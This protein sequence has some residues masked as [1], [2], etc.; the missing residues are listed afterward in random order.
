MRALKLA[1]IFAVVVLINFNDA[2]PASEAQTRT[3]R[4][5]VAEPSEPEEGSLGAEPEEGGSP[6]S[7]PLPDDDTPA[8]GLGGATATASVVVEADDVRYPINKGNFGGKIMKEIEVYSLYKNLEH[9]KKLTPGFWTWAQTAPG[10]NYRWDTHRPCP[11][12]YEN[13]YPVFG[14]S[15]DGAIPEADKPNVV[16]LEYWQATDMRHCAYVRKYPNAERATVSIIFRD[17]EGNVIVRD[18]VKYVRFD[19]K[20]DADIPFK[21]PEDDMW[22]LMTLDS[23]NWNP[24]Y[25]V[26]IREDMRIKVVAYDT[27]GHNHYAATTLDVSS[28]FTRGEWHTVEVYYEDGSENGTVAYYLD[29]VRQDI[30]TG[31]DTS[32][33]V[34][35]G[36]REIIL[37]CCKGKS[38]EGKVYIDAVRAHNTYIGVDPGDPR[39]FIR[40]V[41][42]DSSASTIDDFLYF[43]EKAGA[44]PVVQTVLYPPGDN[45]E[46]F[47][48]QFSA[49]LVEYIN[50]E[51]DPDFINKAK[52]LD[53]THNTPSDNWANLRAARGRV[54]PYNVQYFTMGNEPYWAE[55]WPKEQPSLYADACYEHA[56]K[57]KEVDPSI[58]IGVFMY[59]GSGWDRAVLTK[60]EYILDWV[61][62]QHDYSYEPGVN[63]SD[64]VPRLL[65]ISAARF[66]GTGKPFLRRHTEGR[67]RLRQY[68]THRDD[69]DEMITSQDEHGFSL[70]YPPGAG[71]DLGYAIYRLGY[72]LETIEQGG[73]NA[74]DC[75]WLLINDRKYVYGVIGSDCLNPSYWAYRLFYEHFGA[76]YLKVNTSS[77]EYTIFSYRTGA[78]LYETPYISAYA[79]LSEDDST[80][81]I[82]VI[83]RSPDQTIDVNFTLHD[84]TPSTGSALVY[85]LGGGGKGVFDTNLQD[86]NNIIIHESEME[87]DG[88]EFTYTAEPL[89]ITAIE[90]ERYAAPFL[91]A[92]YLSNGNVEMRWTAV[93]FATSYALQWGESERH[94]LGGS[95][96]YPGGEVVIPFGTKLYMKMD[97]GDSLYAVVT[98]RFADGT[99]TALSNVV[100][101]QVM[102]RTT[103]IR[104]QVIGTALVIRW[105]AVPGAAGYKISCGPTP[106]GPYGCN[107][108]AGNH[109]MRVIY[110]AMRGRIYVVVTPY[111][112]EGVSGPPSE[113]IPVDMP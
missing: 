5:T 6:E 43:A 85:K 56:V 10:S 51:A 80:M 60:N 4:T 39:D 19:F 111:N 52:Q 92:R 101:V 9:L 31:L 79:S 89:S 98:A 49:D 42:F 21:S 47:T 53:F 58:K 65:G 30:R 11:G 88:S 61:C 82:I 32:S 18:D 54:E 107:M 33:T 91:S 2:M 41:H 69:L 84:F 102:D 28:R 68:L 70:I 99:Q 103:N 22:C 81:K 20:V 24:N 109:T 105:D 23:G 86:P 67:T 73:P 7:P 74:W 12:G 78:E 76:K 100:H 27:E 36:T 38:A 96:K 62:L 45:R 106:G 95:P 110:P 87:I 26:Y 16:G 64:Q 34:H 29:G 14:V 40:G 48:P 25:R 75:D 1:G 50:G 112:E 104:T 37:G 44:T 35:T 77:P 57:M 17:E 72:R 71:A 8:G 63:L 3:R 97:P 108:D 55:E 93:P 13:D 94:P 66:I 113:I 90:I 59:D 15:G 83:N 46:H